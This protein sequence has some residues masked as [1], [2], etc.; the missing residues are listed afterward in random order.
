MDNN[1]VAA[2]ADTAAVRATTKLKKVS[3]VLFPRVY[4]NLVKCPVTVFYALS[5]QG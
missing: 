4:M 1:K 3:K 2:V 5:V